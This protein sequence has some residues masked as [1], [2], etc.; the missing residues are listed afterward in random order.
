MNIKVG[1]AVGG[2]FTA[3]RWEPGSNGASARCGHAG[4]TALATEGEAFMLRTPR[5]SRYK[6]KRTWFLRCDEHEHSHW[7]EIGFKGGRR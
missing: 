1:H 5:G 3:A 4:C 6:T 7:R 2:L